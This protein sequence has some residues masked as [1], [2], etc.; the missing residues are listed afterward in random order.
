M[1]RLLHLFIPLKHIQSGSIDN[2]CAPAQSLA[3]QVTLFSLLS[4]VWV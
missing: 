2:L 1:W 4:R 3:F